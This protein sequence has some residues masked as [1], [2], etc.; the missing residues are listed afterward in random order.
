[1]ENENKEFLAPSNDAPIEPEVDAA[2]NEAAVATE[3]A[4]SQA[5]P[6]AKQAAPE[7]V[8]A[9][10]VAPESCEV[11]APTENKPP[12]KPANK[13][14]IAIIAGAILAVALIVVAIVYAC[15][16]RPNGILEDAKEALRKKDFY[17]CER[18]INQI[19]NHKEIPALQTKL[20]LAMARSY[21]EEGNLDLAESML[22][23]LPGNKDA[24]ELKDDIQYFRAEDLVKHEQYEEAQLILDKIPNYEDTK[25][26]H[27]QILYASALKALDTGDYETAYDIF[28]Q[29]G[30]FKDAPQQKEIV[31]YEALAFKSLFNIQS[32][33]KNPASLR[34]TKVT[35]YKDSSREGELDAV[36]EITATNSYGGS[37]GAYVYDLT[38]YDESEDSGMISHSE[39][40]DQDT[41]LDILQAMLVDSIRTETVH[42]TT[43]DVARMNRLL[44][45][46]ASFKINLPFQSGAVVEN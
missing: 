26:L 14:L 42:E 10:A 25:Q 32:T 36:Y 5:L 37:L 17:E 16:I 12:R 44:E 46:N 19:P 11:V 31:Y 13:K 9:D 30:E 1:M 40:A 6:D 45:G 7:A 38:L 18:L 2:Q 4:E 24:K 8:S 43:V 3:T 28:S 27:E 34:V 22:A 33:L 20:D 23:K 41:Y 29:L 15:V 39:Y 21:M 35:F